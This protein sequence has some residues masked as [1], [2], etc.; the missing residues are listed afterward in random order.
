MTV[1]PLKPRKLPVQARSIATVGMILEAAARIL[2]A[3]GLEAYS[4]NAVAEL[5]GVSVGTLYQYF[6][7]KEAM[8]V[9]LI[10]RETAILLSEIEAIDPGLGSKKAIDLLIRA[11]VAHQMRRPALARLLDFEEQRLPLRDEQRLMDLRVQNMLKLFLDDRPTQAA[12]NL[13]MVSADILCLIKGIVDGAGERGETDIEGLE[14]RVARAVF[15]Y[16]RE[17]G[18]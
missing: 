16:L 13:Q 7:N 14:N 4:S 10:E 5:A 9:A 8:T 1:P 12:E 18:A 11:C 2:E 17:D 6:P 15:G 3:R